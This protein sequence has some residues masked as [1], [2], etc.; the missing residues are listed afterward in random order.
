MPFSWLL[1][2]SAAL[3]HHG[4][5]SSLAFALA[6]GIPHLVSP[7]NVDQPYNAERLA[8]LGVSSTVRPG[9]YR[10][11]RVARE[12]ELLLGSAR[13]RRACE[14][15]AA[16]VRGTAALERACEMIEA[17]LGAPVESESGPPGPGSW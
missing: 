6:A 3:V 17:A 11:T 1:A 16:R 14:V 2:R 15:A 10:P 4:G 5:I 9:A 12:L 7:M 8:A 13:V